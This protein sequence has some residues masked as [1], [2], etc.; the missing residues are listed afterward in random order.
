VKKLLI[1]LLLAAPVAGAAEWTDFRWISFGTF[2]HAAIFLPAKVD[3]VDSF[4]QLDTGANGRFIPAARPADPAGRE[5][6]IEVA[7]H[8]VR[9]L[10]PQPVH[11]G[12]RAGTVGN[13]FF[14][15]GTLTIDLKNARFSYAEQAALRDDS[16]AAPFKY[17]HHEGWDGGHIVVPLSLPD[18]PPQDAMFDTGAAIFTFVP[19]QRS[20]YET[21][22]GAGGQQLAVPSWG[23]DI[24]CETSPL[25]MPLRV[26]QYTL[27][28]GMLGL[29]KLPVDIGVPLAGVIGLAG[30]ADQTITIDY[31]S[32]RWKITR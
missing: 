14:E 2:K 30:L 21:L 1:A 26:S 25:G 8:T 15:H 18:Q 4:V 16:T 19:L 13:A 23:V 9:A 31:P 10:L 12:E 29:C 20:L 32:R 7:S 22:R 27:D 6:N 3:G 5:V 11:A 24:G 17:V 28:T